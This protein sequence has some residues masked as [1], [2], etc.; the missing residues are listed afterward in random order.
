MNI[1]WLDLVSNQDMIS[2]DKF[3]FSPNC[4]LHISAKQT[5]NGYMIIQGKYNFKRSLQSLLIKVVLPSLMKKGSMSA[6]INIIYNAKPNL[7]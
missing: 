6:G 1:I 3:T 5:L 4:I 2:R 7:S